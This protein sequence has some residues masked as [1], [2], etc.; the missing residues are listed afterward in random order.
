MFFLLVNIFK[1]EYLDN[2]AQADEK[3]S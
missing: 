1:K 2:P 3:I